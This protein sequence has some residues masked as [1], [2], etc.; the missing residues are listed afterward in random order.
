MPPLGT[1]GILLSHGDYAAASGAMLLFMTNFVSIVLAASV[2]FVLVGVVPIDGLAKNAERTQGWFV[3]F[4]VAGIL[5]LIPLA[6]GGQ[7][8]FAA[9]TDD[10]RWRPP[11]SR[12]GWPRTRRSSRSTSR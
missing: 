2:V 12:R 1:V 4:A 8:A 6:V 3:S 5:L 10:A 9:A 7:Q 11:R